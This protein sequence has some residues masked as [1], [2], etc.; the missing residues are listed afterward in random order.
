MYDDSSPYIYDKIQ[1][2]V[3]YISKPDSIVNWPVRDTIGSLSGAINDVSAQYVNNIQRWGWS[4]R[5]GF[6][7]ISSDLLEAKIQY[8]YSFINGKLTDRQQF[9]L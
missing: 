1:H 6:T 9:I 7:D 3:S 5:L 8:G 4:R 2:I